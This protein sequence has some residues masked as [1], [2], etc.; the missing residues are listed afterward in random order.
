MRFREPLILPCVSLAAGVVAANYAPVPVP[1]ALWAALACAALGFIAHCFVRRG[2]L[3]ARV[4]GSAAIA[5]AGMALAAG[6]HPPAAPR[7]SVPDNS[8]AIFEGCVTDPALVGA[9]RERFG[10]EP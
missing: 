4:A 9:D 5:F 7:L 6:R 1:S 10:I 3:A 8:L 2:C